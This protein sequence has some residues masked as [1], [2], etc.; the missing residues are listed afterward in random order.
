MK[1][2]E[3]KKPIPVEL[4]D[5][6]LDTVA[7]G[8]IDTHMNF[9]P[10][11]DSNLII[12]SE[13]LDDDALDKVSGGTFGDLEVCPVCGK[14]KREGMQCSWCDMADGTA[15]CHIC[16]GKVT[17]ESGCPQCNMSWDAYY[18]ATKYLRGE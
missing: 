6:A 14:Q 16:G 13:E 3:I 2:K 11:D 18:E 5:D 10:S 17:K 7:G 1:N 8:G 12:K 9:L 4:N 15:T